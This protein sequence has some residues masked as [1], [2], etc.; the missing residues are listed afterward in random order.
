MPSRTEI[1]RKNRLRMLRDF[2]GRVV[3]YEPTPPKI[4]FR[5]EEP[6]R[7]VHCLCGIEFETHA[8]NRKLCDACKQAKLVVHMAVA[9]AWRTVCRVNV[10]NVMRPTTEKWEEVTCA[11]C[12]TSKK[13]MASG[14]GGGGTDGG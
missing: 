9:D 11:R 7:R 3:A 13:S 10:E 6:P 12:L 1:N 5:T 2:G 8:L 14:D 4:A